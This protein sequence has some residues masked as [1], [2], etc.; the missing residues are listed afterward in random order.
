MTRVV[1]PRSWRHDRDNCHFDSVE[2]FVGA[3]GLGIGVGKAGF[4]HQL[5]VDWDS[6]ACATIR[7]N[8][9]LNHPH[10]QEPSPTRPVQPQ[11]TP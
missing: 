4:A 1:T 5:V 10:P 7:V 8:Q 11:S 6:H 9:S 3:G 2:L